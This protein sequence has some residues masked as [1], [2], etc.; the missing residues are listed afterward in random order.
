MNIPEHTDLALYPIQF[1]PGSRYRIWGGRL[2][3]KGLVC[4]AICSLLLTG[5]GL[6]GVNQ[7]AP[8]PRG[9]DVNHAVAPD[10]TRPGK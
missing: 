1:E 3:I 6:I 5:C 4:A 2:F 10:A 9:V 8:A 7:I